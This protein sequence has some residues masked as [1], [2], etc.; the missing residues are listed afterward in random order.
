MRQGLDEIA[1]WQMLEYWMQVELY[2]AIQSDRA[3]PWRHIG[4]YEHP[5]HTEMPLS[6]SKTK[7][8]WIDLV[9]AEPSVETPESV[10][11]IELKDIGR[12]A[13]NTLKKVKDLGE[14]LAALWSLDPQITKT[15]WLKPHTSVVSKD[16][17]DKE[18]SRYGHGLDCKKHLI[19]QIVLCYRELSEKVSLNE[20]KNQWIQSFEKKTKSTLPAIPLEIKYAET[21]KF[22][23]YALVG[24]LGQ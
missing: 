7:T 13:A 12:N 1:N 3:G 9:L 8:K 6:R 18:W 16:R 5:Y 2:R 23:V 17:F 10:V 22:H 20:I 15:Y 21:S 24:R 14:D 11:W 19:S 4:D